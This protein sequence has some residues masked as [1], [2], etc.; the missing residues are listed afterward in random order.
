MSGQSTEE[1]LLKALDDLHVR[2]QVEE[3]L[4]EMITDVEI[5]HKLEDQVATRFQVQ[6]LEQQIREQDVALLETRLVNEQS[7]ERQASLADQFVKELWSLSREL[8]DLQ[9]VK[10][11]HQ[12][13][14]MQHDE[15]LAKLLQ[16]EQELEQAKLDA[17]N[18]AAARAKDTETDGDRTVP[19]KKEVDR[20]H[21]KKLPH[22]EAD[23]VEKEGGDEKPS[24]ASK[25]TDETTL[26]N[27]DQPD[28]S[29]Q[30]RNDKVTSEA[31]PTETKDINS[32]L[33]QSVERNSA[34]VAVVSLDEEA[35]EPVKFEEFDAEILMNIFSFLDAL[36][37]LN[38]AQVNICMYSRVDSLFGLG[39]QESREME[40][41]STIATTETAPSTA[42]T[43]SN[44]ASS[45]K[46]VSNPT[47]A[48]TPSKSTP[49]T[50]GTIVSLPP[51]ATGSAATALSVTSEASKAAS[52]A[53]GTQASGTTFD[54]PRS[55]F[56][57]ILQPRKAA[58]PQ[59]RQ[60]GNFATGGVGNK[61][62]ISNGHKR[63][64]S[65][66]TS[67]AQ[68]MNAAVANS[69]AAKLSD[70]EL[71]AIIMMTDRLKQKEALAERLVK[72]NE[73]L[74]AKAEGAESVK[75]FLIAKVRDME[76]SL[77]TSE[78]NE[79]KVAQQI[80]SDQEVIAFLD[81]R[82]QELESETRELEQEKQ[83]TLNELARVREQAE[84]KSAVM[85]DMLQFERERLT[86]SEREW[87]ATKKVLVKE[88]KNCRAQ[89]LALQAERDS[90][91]EQS[92]MLKKAVM[93]SSG[94]P[95]SR[96]RFLA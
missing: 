36:D 81:G 60:F 65:A 24:S 87:K 47:P 67:A 85:G 76:L 96:E 16:A 73:R 54:G 19:E 80:A 39:G 91:R 2:K 59:S 72:E 7:R 17:A 37:I 95:V 34:S 89:I 32:G 75:D 44:T 57:S 10:S 42:V 43:S 94:T 45:T 66:D 29:A 82:V 3:T 20:D 41:T 15:V 58:S 83:R 93:S 53:S 25:G 21:D 79:A 9:R 77:S 30:Q 1:A 23:N 40:D 35:D 52:T 70:T 11:D 86:E 55:L 31:T 64:S 8:G 14:L 51:K 84:Q 63:S 18:A 46:T 69:M 4:R 27:E 74:L 22:V 56:S 26:P 68:P 71:N 6:Y 38:T 12:Q 49:S 28:E 61:S 78:D 48:S 33:D 88:V 5:A 62:V 50:T 90:L 13:L 92:E